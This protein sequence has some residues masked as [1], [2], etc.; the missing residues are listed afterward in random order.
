MYT[1]IVCILVQ[2]RYVQG[3]EYAIRIVMGYGI[4]CI[5]IRISRVN[6]EPDFGRIIARFI[7]NLNLYWEILS[8]RT[9][10]LKT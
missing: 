2:T 8:I 5:G 4:L 10:V 3:S 6:T 7:A 1:L 9:Y